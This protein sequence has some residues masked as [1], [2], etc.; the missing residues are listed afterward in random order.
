MNPIQVVIIDNESIVRKILSSPF[1]SFLLG[2]IITIFLSVIIQ[3]RNELLV[4]REKHL[5]IKTHINEILSIYKKLLRYLNPE[6]YYTPDYVLLDED[7]NEEIDYDIF[8]KRKKDKEI[9]NIL[10]EVTR[11]RKDVLP[12]IDLYISKE[13]QD[14]FFHLFDSINKIVEAFVPFPFIM[15]IVYSDE[16]KSAILHRTLHDYLP[17]YAELIEVVYIIESKIIRIKESKKIHNKNRK[18]LNY[19]DYFSK[20]EKDYREEI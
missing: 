20:I 19:E 5:L 8:L 4:K 9:S 6:T 16:I 1:V 15:K 17:K 10:N 12:I 14:I 7:Y 13:N 3:Y 2:S 11:I 18:L